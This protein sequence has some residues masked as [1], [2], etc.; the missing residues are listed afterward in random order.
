MPILLNKASLLDWQSI[1]V[2]LGSCQQW[3]FAIF[4]TMMLWIVNNDALL[5]CFTKQTLNWE[6]YKWNLSPHVWISPQLFSPQFSRYFF[7]NYLSTSHRNC[8]SPTKHFA[9]QFPQQEHSTF[10]KKPLTTIF[11]VKKSSSVLAIISSVKNPSLSEKGGKSA[12]PQHSWQFPQLKEKHFLSNL[13][14]YY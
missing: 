14:S 7:D 1:I 2:D 10:Q 5:R 9:Q 4:P 6:I 3:C 13:Y 12:L 8:L 11:S